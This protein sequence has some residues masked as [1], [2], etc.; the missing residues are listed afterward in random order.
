MIL[1]H[2]LD[3]PNDP[4][5]NSRRVS[6]TVL[7]NV[8]VLAL[9]QKTNDQDKKPKVAELATLEVSMK[10][11]EKLAL[12]AQMGTLSLVLRSVAS[13]VTIDAGAHDAM[14]TAI[15]S[16]PAV[17]AQGALP[18]NDATLTNEATW[19]S[20][21][22]TA[23]PPP[24]NRYGSDRKVSIMRGGESTDVVVP[25]TIHNVQQNSAPTGER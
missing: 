25:N 23:V 12:V 6:E 19:D 18:T 11:A 16:M 22:S 7:Q 5:E 21:V 10:Q 3:R 4:G 14:Q 20:D 9:D 13:D 24:T 8:R 1:A 2:K 15:D 17:A